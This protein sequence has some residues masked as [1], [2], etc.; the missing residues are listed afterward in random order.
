MLLFFSASPSVCVTQ[1]SC[2]SLSFSACPYSSLCLF[3]G[4]ALSAESP[5]GR[6]GNQTG[7]KRRRFLRGSFA[8]QVLQKPERLPC[9]GFTETSGNT[10]EKLSL[11]VSKSS[12]QMLET[13]RRRSNDHLLRVILNS[14][15]WV[16]SYFA[17]RHTGLTAT[18]MF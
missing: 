9:C 3:K 17:N 12:N 7:G 11:N 16:L 10:R 15:W 6:R 14:V 1:V 5:T 8:F 18:F 13:C 4:S 2:L